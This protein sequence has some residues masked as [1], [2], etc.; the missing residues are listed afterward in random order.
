[1]KLVIKPIP[2]NQLF[3]RNQQIVMALE[4]E[5]QVEVFYDEGMSYPD[6]H[7]LLS[8]AQMALFAIE[9]D[10]RQ[11]VEHLEQAEVELEQAGTTTKLKPDLLIA[12]SEDGKFVTLVIGDP[13]RARKLAGQ[14]VRNLT[15]RIRLDVP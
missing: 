7:F 9:E 14:S 13:A 1:M 4:P 2:R 8:L 15:G 3:S 6:R 12:R 5:G 11:C 10:D